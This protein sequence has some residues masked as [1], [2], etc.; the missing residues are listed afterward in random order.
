[1]AGLAPHTPLGEMDR[2]N[3]CS[4]ETSE[5]I[6]GIA[7]ALCQFQGLTH[8]VV[9]DSRNPHFKNRYASLEAVIETVRSPMNECGLAF[10]QAPGRVVNGALEV[11]TM[12]MHYPSGQWIRSTMS[13]PLAKQDPQ[14]VGSAITY[15]CRYALMASLGLPALDDDAE[16]QRQAHE[17]KR[18]P[19]PSNAPERQLPPP[20]ADS[21]SIYVKNSLER[22]EGFDDPE[23][24][25]AWLDVRS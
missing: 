10:M 16:E 2:K 22:I 4:I 24:L 9:K 8:G 11:S 13:L 19:E 21:R 5:S 25:A 7:E 14:G 17:Q 6:K 15:G 12:L 20:T 23:K 18:A 1:M 3:M